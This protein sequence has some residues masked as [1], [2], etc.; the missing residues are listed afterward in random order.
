MSF[1]ETSPTLN[2]VGSVDPAA[3][4]AAKISPTITASPFASSVR[5]PGCTAPKGSHGRQRA[6][7]WC[8][9]RTVKKPATQHARVHN[10]C[11]MYCADNL[12][13]GVATRCLC[14]MPGGFYECRNCGT[15]ACVVCKNDSGY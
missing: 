11:C 2:A 13:H 1:A 4:I 6:C 7:V 9:Q 12:I 15:I 8:S 10:G 5:L 14:A 3:T